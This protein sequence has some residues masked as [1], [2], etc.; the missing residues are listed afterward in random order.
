MNLKTIIILLFAL[1]FTI[2]CLVQTNPDRET[3]FNENW[4]FIRADVTGAEQIAFDDNAWQVLDL[5]HDYSIEDLSGNNEIKQIGPFSEESAGGPS[6]AHTVGGT[7]WYRKH[8]TLDKEDEN[9]IV[10]ILFDG[11]YMNSDVWLNGNKLGTHPYGYTA[12][13]YDLTP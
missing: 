12:F 10:K 7:A 6:T 4:K 11:I 3:N 13:A 9:K 5:P 1:I 2:S 8:F